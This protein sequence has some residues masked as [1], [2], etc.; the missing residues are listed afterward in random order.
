M[1][2]PDR[3]D[4]IWTDF[5]PQAGHEQAGKRPALVLSPAR[6]NRRL[7]LAVVCPITCQKKS[8]A[9]AVPIPEGLKVQGEVL[10]NQITTI[11]WTVRGAQIADTVPA[12][13]LDRVVALVMAIIDPEGE[14]PRNTA[15]AIE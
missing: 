10:A 12:D 8:Y 2:C 14:S 6:Y 11:D 1:S 4:I 13:V 5:N 15:V 3:G 9:L 7:N